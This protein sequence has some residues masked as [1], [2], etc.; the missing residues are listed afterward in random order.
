M[1]TIYLKNLRSG[2][3]G[4]WHDIYAGKAASDVLILGSS[5][6]VYHFNPRILENVLHKTVY[7]LGMDG[8]NI[9]IELARLHV[10]LQHNAKPDIIIHSL[11][12]HMLSR[13]KDLYNYQQFLPYLADTALSKYLKGYNGF[14]KYDYVIPMAK[15]AGE[16]KLTANAIKNKLKPSAN[17]YNTY[18]G[19][20]GQDLV[21]NSD[22]DKAHKLYPNALNIILNKNSISEFED[23][24][25]LCKTLDIKLIFVYSPEYIEGQRFILNRTVLLAMYRKYAE[26]YSIPFLDYSKDPMCMD[27]S[28]FYNSLHMN[29]SGADLFS[30]KLSEDLKPII[31]ASNEILK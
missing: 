14:S 29:K 22:L 13:P 1:V 30:K 23:Y 15:Y 12:F 3:F 21:W 16:W 20:K 9:D 25:K 10:Y 28:F 31:A 8:Q 11:D 24:L 4:V 18:K 26:Y 5:R 17:M 2:D 6:A 19:H 7:N 27:R